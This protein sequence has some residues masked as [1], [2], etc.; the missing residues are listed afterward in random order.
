MANYKIPTMD[1]TQL[2]MELLTL[3]NRITEIETKITV[4]EGM[5]TT[6]EAKVDK[7]T[8]DI[9]AIL[10]MI[11]D[12]NAKL[13]DLDMKK[14]DKKEGYDIVKV[15]DCLTGDENSVPSIK[16]AR[17]CYYKLANMN[18]ITGETTAIDLETCA[19]KPTPIDFATFALDKGTYLVTG[20]IRYEG[21]ENA[22]GEVYFEYD[23][24]VKF[25]ARVLFGGQ[26][27]D[28]VPVT[29][30]LQIVDDNTTVALKARRITGTKLDLVSNNTGKS[31]LAWVKL[32]SY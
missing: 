11:Q 8:S 31:Y 7:N 21:I 20:F 2:T 22:K 1:N 25:D 5:L 29:A 13:D 9:L 16:S 32:D 27:Y 26:K 30:L 3:G 10:Q 17:E 14:V 24:D 28:T 19:L 23:G 4:F 6:L 15:E 12:I 18:R